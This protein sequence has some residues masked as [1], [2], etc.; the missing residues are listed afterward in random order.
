MR[1]PS[2]NMS[3]VYACI[4]MCTGIGQDYTLY[5][6]DNG[7]LLRETSHVCTRTPQIIQVKLP[8]LL[9]GPAEPRMNNIL[10]LYTH[11]HRTQRDVCPCFIL[12]AKGWGWISYCIRNEV[13]IM[14]NN[15]VRLVLLIKLS[16]QLSF[17]LHLLRYSSLYLCIFTIH[18]FFL[19]L[20]HKS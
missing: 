12:C 15:K 8:Q 10:F 1:T 11:G 4:Q 2:P 7:L 3:T 5:M 20:W 6:I 17:T 16:V 19:F 14:K 13:L 9:R 18:T